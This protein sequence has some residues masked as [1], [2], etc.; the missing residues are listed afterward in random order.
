[1]WNLTITRE[2]ADNDRPSAMD[3]RELAYDYSNAFQ[4]FKSQ[5]G[6]VIMHSNDL[7]SVHTNNYGMEIETV[8]VLQNDDTI[9][10]YLYNLEA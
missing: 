10:V 2:Y 7:V 6:H 5:L 9:T 4:E 1:M 8:I 3:H